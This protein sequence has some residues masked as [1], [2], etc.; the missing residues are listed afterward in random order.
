S[1]SSALSC[2]RHN[3][4]LAYKPQSSPAIIKAKKIGTIIILYLY[5]CAIFFFGTKDLR[6]A[7]VHLDISR[8][9]A[10][11][12]TVALPPFKGD[13]EGKI[14]EILVSDLWRSG[15][16]SPLKTEEDQSLEAELLVKVNCSLR[17]DRFHLKGWLYQTSGNRFLFGEHYQGER[18]QI[19]TIVHSFANRI[20]EKI[21]GE[22]GIAF[23]RI[24]FISDESGS[25]ELYIVDYDGQNKKRVTFD[26]VIT[27]CPDWSEDGENLI[28]LS[29]LHNRT[30]IFFH[31]LKNGRRKIL[32]SY[33]GLNAFADISSKGEIALTLSKDGDPEIYAM[34][35]NGS[36][37]R[38]LT[39]RKGV[40]ASPSWSPD[41]K[42]I[43][44][45]SD[46][47]GS[48]QIYILERLT[49][50]VSR[51]TYQGSYNTSPAWAP[52][53]NFIAYTSM[54][55]GRFEICVINL[56]NG[57]YTVLTSGP[58][59]KEGPSWAP[60]GRLLVFSKRL[61]YK[62]DLYLLDIYTEESY[63]L[64]SGKGNYTSPAWSPK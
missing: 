14:R 48:P 4:Q 26:R 54:I 43:A 24:A 44:F 15:L 39:Y 60:N 29:Y 55:E 51:L 46:R 23:T 12:I 32:S 9:F 64:M 11:K 40:D 59:N 62:S 28:Y 3:R 1:Y 19:R 33:P 52:Q 45:V 38:R 10:R 20:V 42:R 63:P 22:K 18:S 17:S 13:A 16:F 5:F 53:G 35:K 30:E 8:E 27:T 47:G 57:E 34:N 56:D 50:K 21:T 37:L 7:G 36:A 25:K 41:G 2:L 49:K 31:K 61:G 58:G 6:A